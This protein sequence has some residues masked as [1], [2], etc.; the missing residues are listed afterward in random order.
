V[1]GATVRTLVVATLLQSAIATVLVARGAVHFAPL[2][3]PTA[4]GVVAG[5]A[6]G[7]GLYRLL[8]RRD[9]GPREHVSS[10]AFSTL[11]FVYIVISVAEEIIWRGY[12]FDTLAPLRGPLVAVIATTVGFALAHGV[13]QGFVGVRFHVLTG[14]TFA[15][16]LL[17]TRSLAAAAAAHATYNVTVFLRTV[18]IRKKASYDRFVVG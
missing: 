1:T 16:T 17:A 10:G 15:L 18:A 8:A 6:T 9:A 2:T 5:A 12:A 4:L 11:T 7:Y 3:P 14:L 13:H